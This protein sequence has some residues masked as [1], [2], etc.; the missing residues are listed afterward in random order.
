[1]FG[2]DED[3]GISPLGFILRE[4]DVNARKESIYG[5]IATL[6]EWTED[7]KEESRKKVVIE[8]DNSMFNFK[9]PKKQ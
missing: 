9:L 4:N 3:D 8:L 2:G 6:A 1:M 7:I 5:R